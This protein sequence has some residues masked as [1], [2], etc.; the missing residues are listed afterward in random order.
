MLVFVYV[1][2]EGKPSFRKP[3]YSDG[4][5]EPERWQWECPLSA[6]LRRPDSPKETHHANISRVFWEG[7]CS[8]E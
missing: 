1:L 4:R 7:Q 2:L 3:L 8:H 6:P 5:A